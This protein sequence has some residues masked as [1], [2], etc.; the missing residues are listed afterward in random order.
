MVESQNNRLKLGSQ[1]SGPIPNIH[2]FAFEICF[3]C[4]KILNLKDS[5]IHLRSLAEISH[6]EP[7][8]PTVKTVTH[9]ADSWPCV[10]LSLVHAEM[11]ISPLSMD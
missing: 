4:L 5:G 1:W 6:A 9:G 3:S 11:D 2:Y 8:V 7:R 10:H